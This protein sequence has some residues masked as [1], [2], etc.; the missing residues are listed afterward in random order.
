MLVYCWSLKAGNIK[1]FWHPAKSGNYNIMKKTFIVLLVLLVMAVT[2]FAGPTVDE[3]YL[4]PT[5]PEINLDG[6]ALEKFVD[7]KEKLFPNIKMDN[8]A[9]IIWFDDS[10]KSKTEYSVV[11]LHGFSASQ[12]EGI[13]IHTNFAKRYGCNLYLSRLHEHG[14]YAENAMEDMTPDK[15][16]KS[17]AEAIA[18]GKQLG[19]KV[20]LMSTS[21]GSTLSL[22]LA[23]HHPDIHALILYS[24]N[25]E[26]N[27]AATKLLTRPWGINIGRI[28]AGNKNFIYTPDSYEDSLYWT[29][30]YRVEAVAYL[31]QLQDMTMHEEL[32]EQIRQPAFV[33][34]YYKNEEEQDPRVRVD[35]I[36]NMFDHLGTPDDLKV[37]LAVP[38]AGNHVIACEFKSGDWIGVQEGTFDFAEEIL[39]LEPIDQPY[40]Q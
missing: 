16:V 6:I 28:F 32:F 15:L 12:G 3:V 36:L 20:I 14:L 11:Y 37:K 27:N 29:Q 31:R 8:Q 18:I 34:Y 21:N 4:D 40:I 5:I 9:R 24:P 10:L 30:A 38:D 7:E 22:Y 23:A 26:I 17:A 13:P 1:R 19:T 25:I 39:G 2:Y 33:A 35:A